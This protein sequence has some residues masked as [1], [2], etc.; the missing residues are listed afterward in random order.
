MDAARA[1]GIHRPSA[2]RIYR[3][4]RQQMARDCEQ[5]APLGGDGAA[6]ASYFGGHRKGHRGRGAAG[7][8]AVLGLLKRRGKVYTR[9]VPNVTR[10]TLRAVIRQKGPKG[11]TIDSGPFAVYDGLITQG[12]RHYRINHST[13]FATTRRQHITGIE[14]FWGYAK[15]KLKRD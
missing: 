6:D 11:R 3:V 4:S 15:T 7:T 14:H 8:V 5:H 2:A 13:G 1:I 10:A 9:P 12:Y